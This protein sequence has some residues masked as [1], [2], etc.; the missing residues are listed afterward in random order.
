MPRPDVKDRRIPDILHAAISVFAIKGIDGGSVREIAG[1]A[2]ISKATVFHY[3]ESKDALV[4][5]VVRHIFDRDIEYFASPPP[6][7][8]PAVGYILDYARQLGLLFSSDSALFN[9]IVMIYGR[10]IRDD[11]IRAILADYFSRYRGGLEKLLQIGVERGEI[12]DECS[13]SEVAQTAVSIIEGSILQA[14][15]Q[16]ASPDG[17]MLHNLGCLFRTISAGPSGKNVSG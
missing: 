10:A 12:D 3:Y 2:G 1:R 17:L 6:A 5:G 15:V 9:C 13:V 7:D 11:K 14:R 4:E 8:I 16:S